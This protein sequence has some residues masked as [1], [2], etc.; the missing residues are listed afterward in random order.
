[1][2][3]MGIVKLIFNWIFEL[4]ILLFMIDVYIDRDFIFVV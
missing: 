1:M 3:I 4:K 2:I